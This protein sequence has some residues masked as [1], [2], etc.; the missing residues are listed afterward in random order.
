MGSQQF[1]IDH[2]PS[3]AAPVTGERPGRGLAGSPA[4][5]G[6]SDTVDA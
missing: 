4:A 3:L 1:D 6:P 2:A 5:L